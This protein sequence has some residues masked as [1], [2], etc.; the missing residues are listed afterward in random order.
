MPQPSEI[1]PKCQT[2][3]EGTNAFCPSCAFPLQRVAGKYRIERKLGEGGFGAVFLAKHIH[4]TRNPERVVKVI[5]PELLLDEELKLRFRREVELTSLL[6]Q[7]NEHIVRIYD[8]FGVDYLGHYYVMEYLQGQD[9]NQFLAKNKHCSIE[10]AVDLSIQ[11]CSALDAAHKERIIH[12]DLKPDNIYLVDRPSQQH[13]VKIIDF[14]IAKPLGKTNHPYLTQNNPSLLGTP[15][16]MAPEQWESN[17]VSPSSDLYAIGIIL[18]ELLTGNTPFFH[19]RDNLHRLFFAHTS[20][21]PEPMSSRRPDLNIPARLEQ[22]VAKALAKHPEQRFPDVASFSKALLPFSVLNANLR[23]V[24]MIGSVGDVWSA[25]AL[26]E[27][28]ESPSFDSL[29]GMVQRPQILSYREESGEDVK[30]IV[31]M[32]DSLKDI[33]RSIKITSKKSIRSALE[34][35]D[36]F[37]NPRHSENISSIHPAKLPASGEVWGDPTDIQTMGSSDQLRTVSENNPTGR[38]L[39]PHGIKLP[40]SPTVRGGP[41][42]TVSADISSVFK[43]EQQKRLI[44]TLVGS[45]LAALLVSIAVL[46]FMGEK[47]PPKKHGV[48]GSEAPVQRVDA[49]TPLAAPTGK[50]AQGKSRP[51]YPNPD[52]CN[53]KKCLGVC[54]PGTQ[55]CQNGRWSSCQGGVLPQKERCNALDDDCDGKVDEAFSKKNTSC[56]TR[57][58]PAKFLCNKKGELVC[59]K[60]KSRNI[61]LKISPSKTKFLLFFGSRKQRSVKGNACIPIPQK[62]QRIRL[63]N[64][65]FHKCTFQ[66]QAQRSYDIAMKKDN[67]TNTE[68]DYCIKK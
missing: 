6:S 45:L 10:K 33:A 64:S 17:R 66:A 42:A 60:S 50:C 34:E 46:M 55:T 31:D 11:I 40:G 24:G 37:P 16:Y 39:T 48:L 54:K 30:T 29:D 58:F 21:P 36:T 7:K 51:C 59:L 67:E 9:L 47:P 23:S 57:C 32:E 28:I 1:C 35:Q 62:S 15:E 43:K 65:R 68:Q 22:I 18:Y 27:T 26:P 2:Q 38:R 19:L 3:Q 25:N 5:K 44:F 8:D 52:K 4:L 41:S 63:Y 20:E 13:F 56:G 61:Q 53:S 12:R 14:G 49:G